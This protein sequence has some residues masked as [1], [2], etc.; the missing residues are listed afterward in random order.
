[1]RLRECP[2]QDASRS[3]LGPEAHT[4]TKRD[5]A[6]RSAAWATQGSKYHWALD[7]TYGLSRRRLSTS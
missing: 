3:A 4:H 6:Q 7:A 2:A 5:V 1:M